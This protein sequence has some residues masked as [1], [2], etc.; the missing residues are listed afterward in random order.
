[1]F[2]P[3]FKNISC[4]Q[5]HYIN[6]FLIV[7]LV[8][9]SSLYDLPSQFFY[10][11]FKCLDLFVDRVNMRIKRLKLLILASLACLVISLVQ[12]IQAKERL[13]VDASSFQDEWITIYLTED[14]VCKKCTWRYVDASHVELK[15]KL[16]VKATYKATEILGATRHPLW[17]KFMFRLAN[18]T[19]LVGNSLMVSE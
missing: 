1:M 2:W 17:R 8:G 6:R 9:Q 5:K 16:G 11:N 12:S 18:K 14:R 10:L 7:V 3:I 19:A 4:T 15:N 13:T